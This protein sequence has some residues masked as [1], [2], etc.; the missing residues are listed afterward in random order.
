MKYIIFRTLFTFL[1][2]I[3]FISASGKNDLKKGAEEAWINEDYQEAQ[4]LYGLMSENDSS[5]IIPALYNQAL[6]LYKQSDFA[7]AAKLLSQVPPIEADPLYTKFIMLNGNILYRNSEQIINTGETLDSALSD[8]ERSISWYKRALEIDQNNRTASHNLEMANILKEKIQIKT[9]EEK[10]DEERKNEMQEQLEQLKE[11]Q[12]QLADD[13]QKDSE[14]HS[15]EQKNLQEETERI[16]NEMNEGGEEFQNQM[17]KA[18]DMQQ[19]ALDEINQGQYE[20][21]EKS[22][23]QA[24]EALEKAIDTFTEKGSESGES[25]MEDQAEEE[26]DQIARSIIENENN[27]ESSSENTG[28]NSIVDRNW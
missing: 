8:I 27:R 6:S 24:V 14:D 10:K 12:K 28:E 26:N 7:N 9:D 19:K 4:R 18:E 21:A 5:Q 17:E 25:P 15:G 20:E 13:N 23:N 3:Q 1:L 22:Q 16:K 11:E 2:C